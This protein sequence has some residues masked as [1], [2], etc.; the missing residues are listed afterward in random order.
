MANFLCACHFRLHFEFCMG[1]IN[2]YVEFLNLS[3]KHFSFGG[4]WASLS[5]AGAVGCCWDAIS[6]TLLIEVIWLVV[7]RFC[8]SSIISNV[9]SRD[10]CLLICLFFWG[11]VAFSP[12]HEFVNFLWGVLTSHRMMSACLL[13]KTSSVDWKINLLYATNT[14]IVNDLNLVCVW[15]HY[16][17]GQHLT[18]FDRQFLRNMPGLGQ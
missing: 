8:F 5:F 7:L 16:T 10:I 17:W 12:K 4:G 1:K 11:R 6:I 15:I 3:I 18:A 13:V 2:E 9:W 14:T